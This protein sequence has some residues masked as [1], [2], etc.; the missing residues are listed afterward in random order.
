M[1]WRGRHFHLTLP[2]LSLGGAAATAGEAAIVSPMP[3]KV[4]RVLVAEGQRVEAGEAVAVVEAMKMEHTLRAAIDGV[5][6]Q[7]NCA[8]GGQ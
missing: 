6:A 5:V 8:E 7:I 4:L 1:W 2:A 3:G